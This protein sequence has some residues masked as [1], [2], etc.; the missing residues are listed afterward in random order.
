M[1]TLLID[2]DILAYQNAAANEKSI[3]WGDGIKTATGSLDEA[4]KA[5]DQKIKEWKKMLG[6]SEAIVCLTDSQ[7]FRKEIL[8]SYKAHRKGVLKPVLLG[9]VRTHL[10]D[11]QQTYQRPF[12]EAD[13]VMGIL[14][15]GE[16]TFAQGEKIIVSIDK[17]MKSVPGFLFNPSKVQDGVIEISKEQ[18]DREHMRQT[19]IGDTA[20]NYKGCPGIGPKKADLALCKKHPEQ[21]MWSLVVHQFELKGLTEAD[22]L[23]QAQVA[24]ICREE[25]YDYINKRPIPWT[26]KK[27][28]V[29]A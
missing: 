10:R 19:L 22:A 13:D 9:D 7:N 6:A 28:Q 12:L 1:R 16:F 18:A 14:A 3:D 15:T 21:T 23:V 17:D 2:G 11:T 5:C 25:D 26:P 24:R 20:D 8:P 4:K 27:A 29:A